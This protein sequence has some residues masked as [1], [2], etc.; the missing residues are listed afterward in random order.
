MEKNVSHANIPFLHAAG[1]CPFPFIHQIG[2]QLPQVSRKKHTDTSSRIREFFVLFLGTLFD[3]FVHV[4]CQNR[5]IDEEDA[6]R[7]WACVENAVK[8]MAEEGDEE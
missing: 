7:V 8:V 5:I 6:D 3:P 4:F 2:L 1:I